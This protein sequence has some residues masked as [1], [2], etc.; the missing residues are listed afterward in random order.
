MSLLET[1]KYRCEKRFL[2]V[3]LSN[4]SECD[5]RVYWTFGPS[6]AP[7]TEEVNLSPV[8]HSQLGFPQ[9]SILTTCNTWCPPAPHHVR[10]LTLMPN[11]L[12]TQNDTSMDCPGHICRPCE[13]KEVDSFCTSSVDFYIALQ[14]PI[15]WVYSL[16]HITSQQATEEHSYNSG[17]IICVWR[18]TASGAVQSQWGDVKREDHQEAVVLMNMHP[19]TPLNWTIQH[20]S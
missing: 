1:A 6:T 4:D 11:L 17:D 16:T 15:L 12:S 10:S 5:Q 9:F 20:S 18:P 13:G 2:A 7:N 3:G 8:Q 14:S 19:I